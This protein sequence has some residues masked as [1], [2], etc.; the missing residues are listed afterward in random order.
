V[1][2][3]YYELQ[4]DRFVLFRNSWI[5]IFSM[6]YVTCDSNY[7][8]VR[9]V[10]DNEVFFKTAAMPQLVEALRYKPESRGFYS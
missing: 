4:T 5:C 7:E 10:D 8:S 9:H 1:L 3:G 2:C 6:K